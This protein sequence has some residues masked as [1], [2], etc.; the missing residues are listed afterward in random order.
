MYLHP[1]LHVMTNVMQVNLG[2]SNIFVETCPSLY[3]NKSEQQSKHNRSICVSWSQYHHYCSSTQD[4]LRVLFCKELSS[5]ISLAS[6]SLAEFRTKKKLSLRLNTDKYNTIQ[7]PCP[8]CTDRIICNSMCG[9]SWM[10][11]KAESF[12]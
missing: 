9:Q 2:G 4:N 7:R 11:Q 12:R 5:Y 3:T 1:C 6:A 8:C 10:K